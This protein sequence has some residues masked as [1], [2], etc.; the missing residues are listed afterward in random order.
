MILTLCSIAPTPSKTLHKLELVLPGCRRV[1]EQ[2]TRISGENHEAC[3]GDWLRT[4]NGM[5]WPPPT[6]ATYISSKT[7][8]ICHTRRQETRINNSHNQ[9]GEN[10]EC[11][12]EF[13]PIFT[14]NQIWRCLLLFPM[15]SD[16]QPLQTCCCTVRSFC[17]SLLIFPFTEI[18]DEKTGA[19]NT[20]PTTK[21]NHVSPWHFGRSSKGLRQTTLLTEYG[22]SLVIFPHWLT[23]TC[24]SSYSNHSIIW[25][26]HPAHQRKPGPVIIPGRVS[27]GLPIHLFTTQPPEEMSASTIAPSTLT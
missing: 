3:G 4:T 27:P 24:S 16:S 20:V 17:V 26:Q 21:E 25:L 2:T 9:R 12:T 1:R 5:R 18:E 23:R 10:N 11:N 13:A 8:V 14:H 15:T 19:C 7:K 6:K 22:R